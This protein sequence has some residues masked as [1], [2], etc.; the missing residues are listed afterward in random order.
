MCKEP[1]L[2]TVLNKHFLRQVN[3]LRVF[4]LYKNSGCK[5]QGKLSNLVHH[6]QSCSYSDLS[7]YTLHIKL[8][9]CTVIILF[10]QYS[11]E[12]TSGTEQDKTRHPVHETKE[13]MI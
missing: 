13:V 9:I 7:R 3:E 5:W 6:Y 2:N 1:N 8:L 4:C 10:T 12:N 11:E